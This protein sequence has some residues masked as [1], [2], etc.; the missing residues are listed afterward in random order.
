MNN[1][2]NNDNNDN[3]NSNNKLARREYKTSYDWMDK[4]IHWELLQKD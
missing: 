2:N 1:N 3:D 4:V